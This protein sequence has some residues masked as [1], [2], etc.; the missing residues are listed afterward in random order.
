MIKYEGTR[1][2][3]DTLCDDPAVTTSTV[4]V[5]VKMV[6]NTVAAIAHPL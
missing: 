1:T 2:A 6:K 4:A 5:T 3:A